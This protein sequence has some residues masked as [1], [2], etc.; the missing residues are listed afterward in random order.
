MWLG[1]CKKAIAMFGQAQ[2][3]VPSSDLLKHELFHAG[4]IAQ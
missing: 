1:R 4:G 2:I 3:N